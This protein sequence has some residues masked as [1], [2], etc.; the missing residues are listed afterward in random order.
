[1][2]ANSGGHCVAQDRNFD[3]L[4]DRFE[5]NL[6][7]SPKGRL[8]LQLVQRELA[9]TSRV[10]AEGKP[11]RV[12]DLGC[13]LGQMAQWLAAQGHAVTACDISPRMVARARERIQSLDPAAAANI[14][15][16]AL[17]LQELA[18]SLS[19]R[20]E[21]VL[22]HAV[23]EWLADPQAGLREASQWVA[24]DGELSLLFYNRASLV[25][26]NLLRGDFR[27]VDED[28][29][30]GDP[31]GLTPSHPLEIDQVHEWTNALGLDIVSTRGIR[32]FSDYMPQALDRRKPPT[33][34][35]EEI[36]RMEWTIGNSSPFRELARYQL[37]LA[38]RRA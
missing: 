35:E 33:A 36:L 2:K 16:R 4:T 31:G 1:M 12:L 37:W 9:A 7:G 11:L 5:R 29:F 8:R 38:K 30:A 15:F 13:G 23:I 22:F 14:E 26:K 17:S 10:L 24:D 34:T 19:G 18:T 32:S 6:Y 27:R 25:F 20:F 3:D 28:D 21:L